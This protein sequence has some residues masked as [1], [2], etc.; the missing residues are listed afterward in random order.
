MS[1]HFKVKEID[2][3]SET[4]A[5]ETVIV[6]L[7]TGNYYSLRGVGSS[8]W[9]MLKAGADETAIMESIAQQYNQ[10]LDS[11]VDDLNSFI[12]KLQAE[13]LIEEMNGK[14]LDA[15]AQPEGGRVEQE[16]QPPAIETYN[17]MQELLLLDPV[18]DVDQTGWP[19]TKPESE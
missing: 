15:P 19:H 2:V 12:A 14:S 6:H 17:D 9:N 7:G 1:V 10:P 3:H 18:H 16:Y 5:G 11:I 13:Q 4:I 8:I